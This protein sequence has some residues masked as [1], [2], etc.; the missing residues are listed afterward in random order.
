MEETY[1]QPVECGRLPGMVGLECSRGR[2]YDKMPRVELERDAEASQNI[3]PQQ[4]VRPEA[5]RKVGHGDLAQ[6][7]DHPSKRQ[8][9]RVDDRGASR[10]PV[11]THQMAPLARSLQVQTQPV[12]RRH[13]HRG[14]E[15]TSIHQ[16]RS[17]HLGRKSDHHDGHVMAGHEG[18]P[19]RVSRSQNTI[20]VSE[21][22]S[23]TGPAK[24]TAVCAP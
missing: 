9:T 16:K 8:A 2:A 24:N 6:R 3:K 11:D 19:V 7:D 13:T 23:V 20:T 17:C 15:R 18:N 21:F 12:S 22:G 14:H 4:A 5:G 10:K 1:Q